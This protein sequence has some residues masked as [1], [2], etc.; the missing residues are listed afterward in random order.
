MKAQG[1]AMFIRGT[2]VEKGGYLVK[3]GLLHSSNI[4]HFFS[5]LTQ[6]FDK[7]NENNQ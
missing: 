6:N 1:T 5:N 7:E 2:A 4:I 3:Q